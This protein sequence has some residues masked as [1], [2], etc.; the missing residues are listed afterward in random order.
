MR[1]ALRE[2]ALACSAL[3]LAM[4]DAVAGELVLPVSTLSAPT[5]SYS[6]KALAT[7]T[8][9]FGRVELNAG[10]GTWSIL[11]PPPSA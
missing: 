3:L 7:R 5:G 8:F 2:L 11:L 9:R 4:G 1:P 6:L 10:G